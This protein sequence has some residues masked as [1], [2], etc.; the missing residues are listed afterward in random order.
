MAEDHD[1]NGEFVAISAEKPDQVE[2]SDEREV[3][4]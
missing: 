4:E 1:L 2:D 3:A